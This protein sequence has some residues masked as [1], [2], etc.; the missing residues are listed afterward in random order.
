[1]SQ[2]AHALISAGAVLAMALNPII[3][4]A[5]RFLERKRTGSTGADLVDPA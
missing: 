3:C 1:M 4:E 5:A 2:G